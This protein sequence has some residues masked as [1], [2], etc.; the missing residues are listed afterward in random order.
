M[1]S[2]EYSSDIIQPMRISPAVLLAWVCGLRIFSNDSHA[3]LRTLDSSNI[4]GVTTNQHGMLSAEDAHNRP[5]PD[6]NT[7]P[8]QSP[9]AVVSKPPDLV[10]SLRSESFAT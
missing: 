5:L 3:K 9:P 2:D 6:V 7:P 1:S 8:I 4:P 10:P